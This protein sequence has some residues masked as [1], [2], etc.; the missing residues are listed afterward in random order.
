[1]ILFK[2]IAIIIILVGVLA[3]V[4]GSFSYTAETLKTN[5]G[6]ADLELRK[7]ETVNIP[8][9]AGVGAIGTGSLFLLL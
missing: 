2:T 1:M 4:Y 3:L 9:W 5:L 6:P 8:L 7:K